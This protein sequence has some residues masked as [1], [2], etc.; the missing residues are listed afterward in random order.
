MDNSYFIAAEYNGRYFDDC[1]VV[2][3]EEIYC[4]GRDPIDAEK[5]WKLSE[6][7][8]GECFET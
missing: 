1:H 7:I 3:T 5:L 2:P 4:W 6:R 8:V